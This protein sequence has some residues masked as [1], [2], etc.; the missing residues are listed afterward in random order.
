[1]FVEK[2]SDI[3][4]HIDFTF[5]VLMQLAMSQTV[6][7]SFIAKQYQRIANKQKSCDGVFPLVTLLFALFYDKKFVIF[8]FATANCI[9]VK[10]I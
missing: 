3:P 10:S 9:T 6:G 4:R 5:V 8:C 2:I 1:M 7:E